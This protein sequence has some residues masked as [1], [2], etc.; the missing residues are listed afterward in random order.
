MFET[1]QAI[2]ARAK[3]EGREVE[4]WSA[5]LAA[6]DPTP[7]SIF[8]LYM[9]L[10]SNGTFEA[11]QY[12]HEGD[13]TPIRPSPVYDPVTKSLGYYVKEMALNARREGS[14][15]PLHGSGVMGINFPQR[16]SYCVFFMD[17]LYWR[18]L[19]ESVGGVELPVII[20]KKD[21]DGKA[22]KVHPHA[23]RKIPLV[24]MEMPNRYTREGVDIRQAAVMINRMRNENGRRLGRREKED[25]CFDF[26]MRVRYNSTATDGLT[27]IVDPTGTN[28]GPPMSPPDVP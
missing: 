4:F 16:F 27:L 9:R 21:K 26:P 19:T 11:R 24:E 28:L 17:D 10:N 5:D 18:F 22:F 3:S 23:F 6:A 15:F 7:H 1:D 2:L 14:T 13:E 20:F 8:F 12:Y 25:F